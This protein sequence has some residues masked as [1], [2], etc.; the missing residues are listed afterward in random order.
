MNFLD[1]ED[2]SLEESDVVIL[3]IPYEAT[4]S[5]GRGSR[6]A[7]SA[8]IEASHY[9]EDYDEE[10]DRSICDEIEIYTCQP[11]VPN[12]TGNFAVEQIY[13]RVKTLVDQNK[14]VVSL[15]GEHTITIGVVQALAEKF[16]DLTVLQFDAHSDLR[17][18]YQG[19][20]Y[21]HACAMYPIHQMGVNLHQIGV[22]AQSKEE[23]ELI[24]SSDNIHTVYAHEIR[25]RACRLYRGLD[26]LKENVY[27]T[28][29]AD[30]FDP[31]VFPSVGTP[32]PGGLLWHEVISVVEKVAM[33]RN[34]VGFDIVEVIPTQEGMIPTSEYTAAKLI[35]KTLGRIF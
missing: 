31:S 8:I 21:S 17:V 11:C 9:V 2:V 7:P 15:G 26:K 16:D 18:S 22:R 32:E 27:I 12:N 30:G 3:P 34:V 24:K 29:D 25:E 10:I 13:R 20:S 6:D 14:F 35:Y 23:A 33:S 19:S 28:F 4:S 5:Y 1:I